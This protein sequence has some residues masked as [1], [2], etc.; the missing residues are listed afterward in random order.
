MTE[1]NTTKTNNNKEN[2]E[3]DIAYYLRKIIKNNIAQT[4]L[5]VTVTAVNKELGVIDVE[6]QINKNKEN[7]L[8]VCA[9]PVLKIAG[10]EPDIK[11]GDKGFCLIEYDLETRN[12]PY[13]NLIYVGNIATLHHPEQ[14]ST[15][16]N[17]KIKNVHK[18]MEI[19]I[20]ALEQ[21]AP[22]TH[23]THTATAM[24][25]IKKLIEIK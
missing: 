8:P 7:L 4:S 2:Q 13:H 24:P 9:V 11:V 14:P 6:A 12:Y 3:R 21:D 10:I 22:A 15:D 19:L 17:I 5:R 16:K 1:Q 25:L 23:A 20:K 18:A